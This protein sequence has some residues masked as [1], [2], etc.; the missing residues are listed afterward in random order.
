MAGLNTQ[1]G[2]NPTPSGF[3]AN[4]MVNWVLQQSWFWRYATRLVGIG[5]GC[6]G[7]HTGDKATAVTGAAMFILESAVSLKCHVQLKQLAESPEPAPWVRVEKAIPV[8][9]SPPTQPPAGL[10]PIH[11]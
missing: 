4:W 3:K 6:L 9:Y 10:G 7:F 2:S 8:N 5:V 1:S 11:H